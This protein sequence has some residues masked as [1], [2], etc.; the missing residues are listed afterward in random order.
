MDGK[1]RLLLLAL[2]AN[3]DR[4]FRRRGSRNIGATIAALTTGTEEV[5]VD[6]SA[7]EQPINTRDPGSFCAT[8]SGMTDTLM[9]L[10]VTAAAVTATAAAAACFPFSLLFL[11]E[12]SHDSRIQIEHD[13]FQRL[14]FV[15]RTVHFI[16]VPY[17]Q[18][19]SR[20][21]ER[22]EYECFADYAELI[23]EVIGLLIE[24]AVREV[25][26]LREQKIRARELQ[27]ISSA[28]T[29]R[30]ASSSAD[31]VFRSRVVPQVFS[32]ILEG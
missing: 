7:R 14:L 13:N 16:E 8:A 11:I 27:K 5:R 20:S 32:R 31:T 9:L 10:I 2:R 3:F 19:P 15:L 6:C 18:M 12:R 25:L 17:V 29:A 23:V 26:F 30:A 1:V 4:G 21:V 28:P 22:S 24:C